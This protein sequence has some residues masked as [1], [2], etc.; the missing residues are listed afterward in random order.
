MTETIKDI[1][2]NYATDVGVYP[3]ANNGVLRST[4]QD[5]WNEWALDRKID[6]E[7]D[8][9]FKKGFL[10]AEN[11]YHIN[12]KLYHDWHD[13]LNAHKEVINELLEREIMQLM[14]IED[15][16]T[17]TVN[18]SDL[19]AWGY[20]DFEVIEE[21]DLEDVLMASKNGKWGIEKMLCQKHNM[22]PQHPIIRSMAEA[23][24]W[25]EIMKNLP[26]NDY[27]LKTNWPNQP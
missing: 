17:M 1:L 6:D 26:D 20:A 8:E 10:M 24:E 25:D 21:E 18:S 7:W 2:C 14:I 3:S 27:N 23:G 4:W 19:F 15:K 11:E 13:N 5:G 22:K 12:L 9:E 16:V